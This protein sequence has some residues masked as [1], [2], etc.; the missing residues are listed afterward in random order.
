MDYDLEKQKT[1]LLVTTAIEE[2]WGND[3][4]II[5][6]GEWCLLYDRKKEWINKAYDVIPCHWADRKKMHKDYD[7]LNVLHDRILDEMVIF[8]NRIH[9]KNE[10]NRYWEML[11]DP[12]LLTYVA[13]IWDRWESLRLLF[14]RY[15]QVKTI[16]LENAAD[17]NIS[18]YIDF[19]KKVLDD[20]WNHGIFLD[21][22]NF[23]YKSRCIVLKNKIYTKKNQKYLKKYSL[24]HRLIGFVDNFIGN[25]FN[26]QKTVIYD[27]YFSFR[28]YISL[29]IKL[30]QFPRLFIYQFQWPS[31][32]VKSAKE[33]NSSLRG[34]LIFR[35]TPEN[36]FESYLF[37]RIQD[38]LP[39]IFLEDFDS[40]EDPLR[41]I[42]LL[43]RSIFTA[44]AHWGNDLFKRWCA[45]KIRD[46]AKIFFMEHGGSFTPLLCSMDFEEVIADKK[47]TW[48]KPHHRN[49]IQLPS[50]K[51]ADSRIISS[52]RYLSVVGYECPR[53]SFRV[54]SCPKIGQMNIQFQM[55]CDFYNLLNES[56]KKNFRVKPYPNDGWNSALRYLNILGNDKVFVGGSMQDFF[57]GARIIVCTYPQTTFSEA[58]I[59][60]VPSILC[61]PKE[62][63]EIHPS[64]HSLLDQMHQAKIVFYDAAKAAEHIN[65]IWS[66]PSAWWETVEV[67]AVRGRFLKEAL[68]MRV[69]W[70]DDWSTFIKRESD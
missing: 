70:L 40:L 56:I 43:P 53:Y 32:L 31:I 46:G 22:I 65:K 12:W 1:P 5:F 17:F 29:C 36:A 10:A 34:E 62:L 7:Y 57:S 35:N 2:S 30:R 41:K 69:N 52:R 48:S 19:T 26:S 3:E 23:N 60:G 64:M 50:S 59:S 15:D 44:N 68:G 18:H 14:E 13:V 28:A 20:E 61:Y 24:K 54:E 58:L 37:K 25:I 27:G 4:D 47:I 33:L 11:L 8:L 55:S 39:K 16:E 63:W 38:D 9:Q 6:L 21:I 51:L 45:E 42:S 67:A 66:D 49:Q